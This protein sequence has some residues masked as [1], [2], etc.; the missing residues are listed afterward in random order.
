MVFAN[1]ILKNTLS[2]IYRWFFISNIN[3]LVYSDI[4][5]K[6]LMIV[7]IIFEQGFQTFSV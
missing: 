2:G 4:L 7:F 1:A 3:D 5:A 6:D